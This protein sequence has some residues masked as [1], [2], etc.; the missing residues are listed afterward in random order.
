M[1]PDLAAFLGAGPGEMDDG[2]EVA[3]KNVA[4]F[5]ENRVVILVRNRSLGPEML[6]VSMLEIG[7]IGLAVDAFPVKRSFFTEKK[8]VFGAFSLI[9]F[10]IELRF[11][12]L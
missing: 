4:I 7:N 12:A 2:L 8:L 1:A 5:Q 10:F 6:H 3:D 11:F 9:K